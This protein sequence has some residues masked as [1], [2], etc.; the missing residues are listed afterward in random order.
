MELNLSGGDFE[1]ILD[2]ASENDFA[3]LDPPYTVL[4]NN[5]GFVKYNDVMFSWEDQRR[6]AGAVDRARKRGVK[7]LLSNADHSS[8]RE[9]Y[10]NIGKL[11][12]IERFSVIGGGTNYRSKT[13]ELLVKVNF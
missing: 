12:S 10:K 8:V 3:Y 9:L 4:H 6:L 2:G 7:I 5:N 1:K 13:S 11:S